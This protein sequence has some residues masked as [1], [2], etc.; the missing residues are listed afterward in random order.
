MNRKNKLALAMLIVLSLMLSLVACNQEAKAPV[1]QEETKTAEETHNHDHDH[2]H[3]HDHDHED[4]GEDSHISEWEGNWNNLHAYL[5]MEEMEDSIEEGAKNGS[6]SVEE[7]KENFE[8]RRHVD[9]DGFVVDGEHVKFLDDFDANGGKVIYE[10]DYE[11]QERHMEDHGGRQM[12]W[13]I[14]KAKNA[15]AKFPILMMM[16]V[17]GEESL[18]HFH[19]R[20]GDDL[21]AMLAIEGWYPTFVRNTSTLSQ[22]AEEIAE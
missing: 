10:D 6:V 12:A 5:K 22:I 1:V 15:D 3:D 9:F 8:K 11:F 13:D 17:H 19:M 7:F 21:E 20:Y 18:P 14:F 4:D 16:E 2:E